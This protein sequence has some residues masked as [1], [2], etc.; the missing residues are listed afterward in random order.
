VKIA[1]GGRPFDTAEI[2]EHLE[3]V[4]RELR[5]PL[6]ILEDAEG[7]A[8]AVGDAELA[9]GLASLTHRLVEMPD[10][11]ERA[12]GA[13]VAVEAIGRGR[14]LGDVAVIGRG[15]EMPFIRGSTARIMDDF[16]PSSES[17]AFARLVL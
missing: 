7:R 3:A 11:H 5:P 10:A 13:L 12:V 16:S 2:R 14:A 6:G 4:R 9:E 1:T 17:G 8:E 15:P